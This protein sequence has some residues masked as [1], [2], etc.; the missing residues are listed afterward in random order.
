MKT[1]GKFKLIVIGV[2]SG[3]IQALNSILKRL[4]QDFPLPIMIVQHISANADDGLSLHLNSKSALCVSEGKDGE[5]II[6]GHVYVAPA[7]Y[8]ML[9][10]PN[11]RIELSADPPLHFARPSIDILFESA[12]D[13]FGAECI[14]IILTGANDDGTAGLFKIHKRGGTTI[15]QDPASAEV[16]IMPQS[17]I[18]A[19]KVDHIVT[20]EIIPTLLTGLVSR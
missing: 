15:V 17:A 8:H 14:G 9:V 12:A 3:G 1:N 2:S 4:P 11:M 19:V 16:A 13:V 20:L 6:P 7:N 10:G 18:S 5:I